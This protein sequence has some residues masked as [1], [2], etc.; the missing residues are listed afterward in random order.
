M[1]LHEGL[2]YKLYKIYIWGGL[3][4]IVIYIFIATLIFGAHNL[5]GPQAFIV[6]GVPIMIWIGG[7]FLYWWWAFLFKDNKELKELAQA[8]N[9]RIPGIDSLGSWNTLHQAMAISGGDI[10]ELIKNAK[11][12]NHPMLFWYGGA[13][14]L[15]LW[16]CC[17]VTLGSL[18]IIQGFGLRTW[19][20]GVFV[21]IV[22]MLVMTAILLGWGSKTAEKAYLAPLGLAITQ[23]PEIKQDVTDMI[24]GDQQLIP[25]NPVIIE[26]ERHGRLVHIETLDKNSLTVVQAQL[27]EFK[28]IS[29]VGKLI[30]SKDA[31]DTVIS[32][33]KSLR[34]AKRWQGVE[35]YSS[36]GGIAVRRKSKGSNKWLYDLWL[37]EYLLEKINSEQLIS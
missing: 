12:A 24:G 11:K 7:I 13:N 36:P 25:E 4:L 14:I 6:L 2:D 31:P 37:D 27:P 34:K 1:P 26:G 33:L 19:L 23:V 20:A 16:I 17:P 21:G 5:P 28:V 35:V 22:L 29:E 32:A 10:Q 3:P 15:A 8:Q 18:E 9:E 30:H